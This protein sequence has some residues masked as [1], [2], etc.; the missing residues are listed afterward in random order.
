MAAAARLRAEGLVS[1]TSGNLSLRIGAQILISP[2]GVDLGSLTRDQIGLHRLDGFAVEA[3]LAPSSELPL[4]LAIHAGGAVGAV[5]HT[6]SA[7][8][9][10]VSTVVEELPPIHYY[11]AEFGAAVRV[12]PYAPFGSAELAA[13]A[14]A[15][16][17]DSRAALLA[18]HGAVVTG[19]NLPEAVEGALILEWLC[20]VYLR[21]AAAGTPHLLTDDQMQRSRADLAEYR[22]RRPLG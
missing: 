22:A 15:A 18:N 3:P 9:V 21:A 16:L 11:L 10:A 2:S 1:G 6:H 4:H 14:A 19:A 12:A 5:V 17:S 13:G 20:E 7:A 8:A